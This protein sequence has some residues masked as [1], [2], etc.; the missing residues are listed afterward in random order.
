MQNDVAD[1]KVIK[2]ESLDP[3]RILYRLG[4][5]TYRPKMWHRPIKEAI[6]FPDNKLPWIPYAYYAGIKIDFHYIFVTAPP[7]SSFITGY[8]LAKRTYRPLIL[9]F[10]DAWLEFPFMP[11]RG[12]AKRTFVSYWEEKITNTASLII[13]VDD[14][15]KKTLIK[16]YPHIEK[17]I[18]VIPNGYDPDD[19][20]TTEKPDIFTVSYL[21]TVREER[22]PENFLSAVNALIHEKEINEKDIK[23]VFIGHIEDQFLKTIRKY[24][25]AEIVGHLPYHHAIR[26]FSSSHCALMVTTGSDYFFPSRQNEYLASG[27]PIIV[28]GKSKAIHLLEDAFKKGYPGWIYDYDDSEGMKNKIFEIYQNFKNGKILRG[29][30]PYKKYTRRSLTKKLAALIERM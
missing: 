29:Q 30:T 16:K 12:K 3:A 2:T 27:L 25:F 17:K 4:M 1:V 8:M 24:A 28:C 18:Y 7:F 5:R 19:F 9:D 11:Y 10:R 26:K 14:N 21:G 13:V 23:V 22:N 6:N 20:V 15:I